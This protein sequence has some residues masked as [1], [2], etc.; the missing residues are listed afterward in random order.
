M[1]GIKPECP[2]CG[3]SEFM[4]CKTVRLEESESHTLEDGRVSYYRCAQ[5]GCYGRLDTPPSTLT[6]IKRGRV[7]KDM[8]K[9][10]LRAL[11]MPMSYADK[12][13]E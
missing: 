9:R 1:P 11:D 13:G 5:C 10:V 2:N 4:Q 7:T 3:S 6:I 12:L 8:A